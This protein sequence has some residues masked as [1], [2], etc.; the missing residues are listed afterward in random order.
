MFRSD[1]IMIIYNAIFVNIIITVV[2]FSTTQVDCDLI[3]SRPSRTSLVWVVGP[4]VAGIGLALLVVLVIVFRYIIIIIK[5]IIIIKIII[6]III[7]AFIMLFVDDEG[8][9]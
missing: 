8:N 5:F 1:Q 6:I 4:V 3:P 2:K 9:R 7:V